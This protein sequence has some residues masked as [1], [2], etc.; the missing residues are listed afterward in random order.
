MSCVQFKWH[1]QKKFNKFNEDTC[2]LPTNAVE[3]SC[4]L[5]RKYLELYNKRFKMFGFNSFWTIIASDQIY[6]HDQDSSNHGD[7]RRRK[8]LERKELRR[9]YI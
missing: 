9:N 4:H 5:Q 8:Y 2:R 3:D 6:G 1:K 7:G